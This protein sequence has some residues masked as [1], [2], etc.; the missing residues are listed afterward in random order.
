MDGFFWIVVV[1][2]I[3]VT[4]G[5]STANKVKEKSKIEDKLLWLELVRNNFD[6]ETLRRYL[7][8][9][10]DYTNKLYS[11]RHTAFAWL[12]RVDAKS[13]LKSSITKMEEFYNEVK[14]K[15]DE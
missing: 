12:T 11:P 7:I 5:A 4:M 8:L 3:T 1:I 14:G 10:Q 15:K 6:E 13:Q 2:L 9:H